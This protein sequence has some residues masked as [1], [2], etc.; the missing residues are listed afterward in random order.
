M[1]NIT[2]KKA[3]EMLFDLNFLNTVTI[4]T[5]NTEF[6]SHCSYL[7]IPKEHENKIVMSSYVK[8]NELVFEIR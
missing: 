2:L 5:L 6:C 7:S 4:K 3:M 8:D 1:N